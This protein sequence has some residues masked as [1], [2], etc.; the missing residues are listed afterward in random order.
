MAMAI[1]AGCWNFCLVWVRHMVCD[2][3]YTHII[4]G[5]HLVA[6]AKLGFYVNR[7]GI[8]SGISAI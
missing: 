5:F 8:A 1:F 7:Y 3:L 6:I 2:C 4:T